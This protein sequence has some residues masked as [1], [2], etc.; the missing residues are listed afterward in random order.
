MRIRRI[1]IASEFRHPAIALCVCAATAME[2]PIFIVASAYHRSLWDI[3]LVFFDQHLLLYH[4][5]GASF[6]I[7][8]VLIPV[9]SGALCLLLS[10]LL[11]AG[12]CRLL[13]QCW[14]LGPDRLL[15]VGVACALVVSCVNVILIYLGCR[16]TLLRT[17]ADQPSHV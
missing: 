6:L 12:I 4:L 16:L 7:L 10:C 9:R 5:I 2:A 3:L 11:C 14:M 17:K 1:R 13:Y 15:L 8:T